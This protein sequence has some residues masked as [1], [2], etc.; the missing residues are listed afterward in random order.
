MK[1]GASIVI[2]MIGP[3]G[4]SPYPSNTVSCFYE[5]GSRQCRF[6]KAGT[7]TFTIT[8]ERVS[9]SFMVVAIN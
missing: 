7:V 1:V 9:R 3:D 8:K 2:T 6:V 5:G 4:F